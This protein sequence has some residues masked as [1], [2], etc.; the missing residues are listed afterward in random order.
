MIAPTAR[1][2]FTFRFAGPAAL[3]C[4]L[5]GVFVFQFFGNATRGYIH[6]RSLFY[7]WGSQWFE[8]AAETQHGLLILLVAAWLFWRDLRIQTGPTAEAGANGGVALAAMLAGLALHLAGYAVQQTRISIAAF[9]LFLW[10]VLVLA[11]G[12][13]WGRAAVFPLGFMLLAVPVSFVDTLGFNLQMVVTNQTYTIAQKLGVSLLRNGTQLFSP[14]GRFQYDVAAACSGIRSLVALLALAL[15]IGRMNF[16]SC[17]AWLVLVVAG[18][19]YVVLGN[20]ARVLSVVLVGE[21]F[22]Q[23]AGERAHDW[24][25]V[26]VFLAVLGLLLATVPLLRRF[27]FKPA[28]TVDE[29][30]PEAVPPS[31]V[32]PWLVAV[33]VVIAA[34]AVCLAAMRLDARPPRSMPGVRLQPDGVSPAE[35]PAFIGAEWV[36]QSVAVT[37]V[38]H[39]VLP[40]DTGFSRRNYVS[41]SDRGRQV[42]V[43]VVLSG[44]DRTSIHRPELCLVGQGWTIIS[45]FRH[46]FPLDGETVPATVLRIE[47]APVDLRAG[48]GPVHSLFAYW[49]VGGEALEPTHIGMQLRDTFDRVRHLR[50]DRWAY[51]VV[52]TAVVQGDEVAA[53]ARMQEIMTGV[54]PS[55]RSEAPKP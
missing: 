39:A 30:K 45:R 16:R 32:Q 23:A 46:E 40:A 27:G 49:F 20:I 22:G 11:G 55:I 33:G 6:T 15:L 44:R 5:V 34:T 1:N 29:T 9:L 26:L 13:R 41:I 50:A 52:Q 36:G 17:W 4:A 28:D 21:W 18:L 14:D 43:S 48:P 38:E 10:G 2:Q 31:R 35:P 54:W 8:P 51:V 3:G 37:E 19:P 24:S 12:R 7:W 25:G 47:H 53:L 42:F